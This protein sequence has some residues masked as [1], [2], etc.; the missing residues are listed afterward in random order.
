MKMTLYEKELA[1]K[2]LALVPQVV[3]ALTKPYKNISLD[4]IEEL[5]QIG[6]LALCKAAM[7]YDNLRPFPAYAKVVIRHEIYDHWRK[8]IPHKEQ[9]AFLDSAK[10]GM[11]EQDDY[12]L[13]TTASPEQT[14][15]NRYLADYL[16]ELKKQNN[17]AFKKG[18]DSLILKQHEYNSTDLGKIYGVPSNH[19]RTWISQ[20]KKVLQK[21]EI[22][23]SLIAS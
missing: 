7:H 22:L 15:I 17:T 18:I 8:C 6:N 2:H 11:I 19:V 9:V 10:R 4:E 20:A 12:M 21:D 16:A 1:E 13:P 3:S 14:V 5:T 23:Y